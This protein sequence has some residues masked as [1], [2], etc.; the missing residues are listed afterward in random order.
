MSMIVAVLEAAVALGE[1]HTQPGDLSRKRRVILQRK[2]LWR[3]V[4]MVD[5]RYAHNRSMTVK[6]RF[7]KAELQAVHRTSLWKLT[8]SEDQG[9]R[10]MTDKTTT[11]DSKLRCCV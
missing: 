4:R 1:M 7:S 11:N 2:W 9:S 8:W 3:Q 5:G 6:T 10:T